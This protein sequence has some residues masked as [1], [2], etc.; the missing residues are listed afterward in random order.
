[1]IEKLFS[2]GRDDS[3]AESN[4][5]E[6]A[7]EHIDEQAEE[8]GESMEIVEEEKVA[9]TREQLEA[10][11]IEQSPNAIATEQPKHVRSSPRK[12]S[13]I[14]R[15]KPTVNANKVSSRLYP[16]ANGGRAIPTN[17]INVKPSEPEKTFGLKTAEAKT[18]NV[19]KKFDLKESLKKGLTYK[20]HSGTIYCRKLMFLGPLKPFAI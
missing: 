11:Q 8:Q 7:D 13:G 5:G 6:H 14:P 1:M 16:F 2:V 4:A 3:A 9:E 20:P 17:P 19:G 18:G 12:L 10:L 15:P